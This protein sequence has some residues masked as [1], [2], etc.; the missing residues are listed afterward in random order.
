MNGTIRGIEG[1][2]IYLNYSHFTNLTTDNELVLIKANKSL[3]VFG[4]NFSNL[5]ADT[6]SSLTIF[7]NSLEGSFN[8]NFTMTE[9]RFGNISWLKQFMAG[10]SINNS[11]SDSSANYTNAFYNLSF[12]NISMNN[13]SEHL[14]SF[15]GS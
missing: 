11:H 14:L 3:T 2:T 8:G 7:D 6:N 9:S 10:S 1:R 12:S 5:S 13:A 15:K 4:A